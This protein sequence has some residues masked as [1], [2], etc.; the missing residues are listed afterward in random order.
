VRA[1][2]QEIDVER[3]DV[4]RHDA[5]RLVGVERDERA[6]LARRVIGPSSSNAPVPNVA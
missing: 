6:D 4:D 2:E 3:R 5:D 1:A